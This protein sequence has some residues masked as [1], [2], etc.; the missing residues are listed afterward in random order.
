MLLPDNLRILQL[1]V[2]CDPDYGLSTKQLIECLRYKHFE[3]IVNA[4]SHVWRRVNMS[5]LRFIEN[6][7]CA[8]IKLFE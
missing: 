2:G 6:K 5:M 4:S 8:M 3:E 7:P 1:Q